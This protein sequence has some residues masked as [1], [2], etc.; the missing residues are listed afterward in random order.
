MLRRV[1]QRVARRDFGG[2]GLDGAR[3]LGG[4]TGRFGAHGHDDSSIV[5]LWRGC[6]FRSVG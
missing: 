1:V 4:S 6:R 3:G 2:P 5:P